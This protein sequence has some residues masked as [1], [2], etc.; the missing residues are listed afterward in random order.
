LGGSQAG[1]ASSG[2]VDGVGYLGG[3]LAGDSIARLSVAYGWRGVFVALT[4]VTALSALAAGYLYFHQRG[5]QR[6]GE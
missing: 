1:A 5:M 2:L 4:A 3:V 6:K